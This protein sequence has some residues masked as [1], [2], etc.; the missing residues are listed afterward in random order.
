[1]K[2][3]TPMAPSICSTSPASPGGRFQTGQFILK[4]E[5]IEAYEPRFTY[6]GFRYVQV[7]GLSEK[8]TLDSLVGRWVHTTPEPAG[9]FFLLQSFGK[10]DSGNH[11][12]HATQQPTRHSHRL[13]A[14]GEDRLDA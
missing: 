3:S 5:G 2:C 8:P 7:K 9:K 10:S 13:S 6:H 4:G 11:R 12:P 14:A 1:M